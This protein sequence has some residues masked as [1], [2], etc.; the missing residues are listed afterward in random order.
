MSSPAQANTDQGSDFLRYLETASLPLLLD[1]A[2]G[3]MLNARGIGFEACFDALNVNRPELV[4]EIHR[5]YIEAGAQIILTNTF[6]A[7]RY[8]L[9]EHGLEDKVVEINRAG[10][11]LARRV[12]LASFKEVLVA[13]DAGPLGVRLAPFGRV[14]PEQ[15]RQAFKQQISVL[16][17]AGADL[18][19][20]E[21]ISD[22]YEMC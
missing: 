14:Q 11:E 1:G 4:A 9:A 2:M 6:G 19:V 7:N 16:A 3:T 5:A 12:V 8:K 22:L 20:I 21:T 13:G 15:A 18:I 17:A 10:V